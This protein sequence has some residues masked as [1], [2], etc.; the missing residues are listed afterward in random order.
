MTLAEHLEASGLTRGQFAAM[1]GAHPITVSKWATGAAMPRHAW[2]SKIM[3]ATDQR[4]TPG[5]FHAVV[6]Q[7]A[8]RALA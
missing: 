6:S 2:L 3:D 8:A 7:R 1:V 4:V 5:D